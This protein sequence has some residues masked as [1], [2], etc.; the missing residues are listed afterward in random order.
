MGRFRWWTRVGVAPLGALLALVLGASVAFAASPHFIKTSASLSGA[1]LVVSFKEAGLGDNLNINFT[2]SADGTATYVCVNKGG[3]N[4]SASNKTVVAGPI[5]ASGTFN[6]GKNGTI[7]ASLTLHPPFADIG[8][9][10]G[11][12]QQLAQA[13][14][15]NV[16]ISD[17]TNG[18]SAS[19]PGTFTTGCLLPN[20]RG[21]C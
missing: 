18:V 1:N 9:P 8:C 19:I 17:T 16:A 4:P 10:N 20:V 12:K 15:T 7:S 2:A 5:S 3:A 6:S 14:Y 13:S 11:Q 21:A